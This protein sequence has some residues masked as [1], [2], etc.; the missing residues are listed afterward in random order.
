MMKLLPNDFLPEY[1]VL[2]YSHDFLRVYERLNVKTTPWEKIWEKKSDDQTHYT[3]RGKLSI[4]EQHLYQH[5]LWKIVLE[6]DE[7]K[8]Q[9]VFEYLR[10]EL[11]VDIEYFLSI[12][13]NQIY[14]TL[15]EIKTADCQKILNKIR[16]IPEKLLVSFLRITASFLTIFKMS[17]RH[18]VGDIANFVV[19]ITQFSYSD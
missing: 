12:H 8:R 9:R 11:D 4:D 5:F 13:L 19:L 2:H 16:L 10:S 6:S 1:D 14:F 15:D 17:I 7:R 18:L 3:L